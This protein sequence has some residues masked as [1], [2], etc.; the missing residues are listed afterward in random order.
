VP[1]TLAARIEANAVAPHRF[2]AV[3]GRYCADYGT[4]DQQD[5]SFFFLHFLS[6]LEGQEKQEFA[7]LP[8]AGAPC[9]SLFA[10][11]QEQRLQCS[12]TGAVS[13]TYSNE[14][15]LSLHIPL[16]AATNRQEVLEYKERE[17]MRQKL[18]ETDTEAYIGAVVRFLC[19]AS[20]SIQRQRKCRK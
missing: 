16:D 1:E 15:Q 18:V 12:V 14:T 3:M 9:S 6:L 4:A 20:P 13:Y 5:A 11:A 10:F 19:H 17:Q 2:K 7:R 8:A